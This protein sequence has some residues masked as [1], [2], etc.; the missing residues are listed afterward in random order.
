MQSFYILNTTVE[1]IQKLVSISNINYQNIYLSGCRPV[2]VGLPQN[3]P[4][5]SL[6]RSYLLNCVLLT[7]CCGTFP[8]LTSYSVD[9]LGLDILSP[10]S[11]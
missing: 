2:D 11:K 3:F 6:S 7:V 1:D 10:S 9:L 4:V 5:L 8:S